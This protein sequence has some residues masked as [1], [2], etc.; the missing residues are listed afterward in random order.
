[1]IQLLQSVPECFPNVLSIF[2]I[3]FKFNIY[4]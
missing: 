2:I 4:Q 3:L 1:M